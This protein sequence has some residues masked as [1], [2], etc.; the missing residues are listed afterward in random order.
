MLKGIEHFNAAMQ[1]ILDDPDLDTVV[2]DT[3]EARER[4]KRNLMEAPTVQYPAFTG[5]QAL[6]VLRKQH[7][8]ASTTL[9]RRKV[10]EMALK[11]VAAS[12]ITEEEAAP[13]VV[14]GG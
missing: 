10:S 7:A 9:Q 14:K 4:R 8:E 2:D 11:L 1:L 12:L 6:A 3:P 5:T 13:F